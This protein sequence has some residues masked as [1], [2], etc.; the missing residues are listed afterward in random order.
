MMSGSHL[1]DQHTHAGIG[2][3]RDGTGQGDRQG[4]GRCGATRDPHGARRELALQWVWCSE[5]GAVGWLVRA[6]WVCVELLHVPQDTAGR[7][8]CL[9]LWWEGVVSGQSPAASRQARSP[10]AR[11]RGGS[12]ARDPEGPGGGSDR[13]PCS[14]SVPGI[15]AQA[16]RLQRSRAKGTPALASGA[17][18]S[19]PPPRLRR[20]VSETSLSPA[21]TQGPEEPGQDTMRYSLY[22]S[23]H[24]LLL[25]GYS[26]QHVSPGPVWPPSLCR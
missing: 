7:L 12:R 1:S 22:E 13:L 19:P 21:A 23:P 2:G 24:L 17:A 4:L 18:H 6:G 15:N 8:G 14:A 3:W 20:T 9:A 25:Q 11:V 26:Q 16:R 10:A 5:G